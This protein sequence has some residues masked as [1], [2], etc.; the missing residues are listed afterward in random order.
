[1]AVPGRNKAKATPKAEEKVMQGAMKLL[2]Y[3]IVAVILLALFY[4]YIMPYFM[5]KEDYLEEINQALETAEINLGRGVT[6]NILFEETSF[7][8][9]TFDSAHRSIAFE[10]NSAELCCN[11]GEEDENCTRTIEWNERK[12]QVKVK[13]P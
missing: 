2:V 7:T 5:P 1:M 8:G 9:N 11:L 10:C 4:T 12:V 13:Q 6:K 3:A